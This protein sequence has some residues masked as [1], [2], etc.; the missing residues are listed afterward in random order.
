MEKTFQQIINKH[1]HTISTFSCA[2]VVAFIHLSTYTTSTTIIKYTSQERIDRL[3]N[4][5]QFSHLTN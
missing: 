4:N 1:I 5:K 3:F 2:R